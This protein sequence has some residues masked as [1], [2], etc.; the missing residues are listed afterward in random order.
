MLVWAY[1]FPLRLCYMVWA[2]VLYGVGLCIYVGWDHR[3][4]NPTSIFKVTYLRAPWELVEA[5]T[6]GEELWEVYGS[7]G[8]VY[9]TPR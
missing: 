1:V 8:E 9:E 4:P 3:S 2:Y 7:I 5:L 6:I